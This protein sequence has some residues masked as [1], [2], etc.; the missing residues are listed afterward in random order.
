MS[1]S[2][3]SRK[4]QRARADRLWSRYIRL[5]DRDT[6]Q[7]CGKP[8]N[9]PH[10]IFSRRHLGT[11]H[12]PENGILLCPYCHRTVAHSD[13]EMFRAFLIGRMGERNFERLYVRAKT[14][15]KPDYAMAEIALKALIWEEG[16]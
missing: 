4:A 3:Q 15:M 9:N 1:R 10:H 7:R 14:V 6:C 8:G 11:R 16:G 13:Y 5:R 2:A 12:D